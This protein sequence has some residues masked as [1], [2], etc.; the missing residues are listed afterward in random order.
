MKITEPLVTQNLVLQTLEKVDI[1][2]NYLAWLNDPEINRYL[3]IRF[4]CPVNMNDLEKFVEQINAS[5]NNLMLGVFHKENGHHIGNVKLGPVQTDHKRADLGFLIGD[6][7]CWGN[8]Y[9]SEAIV[10]ICQLGFEKLGLKKITAGCYQN[11]IGSLKALI[12]SGFEQE[13]ILK[14][15]SICDGQR[16]NSLLFG[17]LAK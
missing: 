6:K 11:N 16:V 2:E 14:S 10:S 12:K 17:M 4:S 9:A 7:A 3:E 5:E 15:Q 1:G 13:A 8:G